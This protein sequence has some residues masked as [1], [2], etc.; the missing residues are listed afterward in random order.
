M[1]IIY[2]IIIFYIYIRRASKFF[3]P[4]FQIQDFNILNQVQDYRLKIL[5]ISPSFSIIFSHFM[6][7]F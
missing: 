5:S 3:P 4:I 7:K 2:L 6:D 1:Y